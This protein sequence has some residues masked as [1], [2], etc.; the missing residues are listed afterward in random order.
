[1][2]GGAKNMNNLEIYRN[3]GVPKRTVDNFLWVQ[4]KAL[5]G[6]SPHETTEQQTTVFEPVA[7]ITFEES[8]A[9]YPSFM[10]QLKVDEESIAK[11]M[12]RFRNDFYGGDPIQR[13]IIL[14]GLS[15]MVRARDRMLE[16]EPMIENLTDSPEPQLG[17]TA[18]YLKPGIQHVIGEAAG[19]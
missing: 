3:S 19:K 18:A 9:I 14:D 5:T 15:Q 16:P 4:E 17:E 12:E 13:A 11:E 7:A 2:A 6:I 10:S 1:M 8:L